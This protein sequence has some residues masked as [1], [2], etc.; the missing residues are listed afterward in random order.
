MSEL[1]DVIIPVYNGEEFIKEA[2]D[3]ILEQTYQNFR[4][5]IVD[6]GS[7]DSTVDIIK[8]ISLSTDKIHLIERPHYG[9]P[10]TIKKGLETTVANRIC[11]LDADDVWHKEKLKKQ[12]EFFNSNPEALASFT[13]IKEFESFKDQSNPPKYKARKE[14]MRG[15]SK[16]TIM[17][18]REILKTY[19]Q[20]NHDKLIGG[21][22]PNI[23]ISMVQDNVQYSILNEV[24][25]YRRV[26]DN[27]M[28]RTMDKND[29]LTLI[30]KH[31][32][33]NK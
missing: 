21:V 31:L 32:S 10:L 16:S 33:K 24:L 15:V 14:A 18:K 13:M 3:S 23:F 1:V 30:K 4:I 26:H 12:I 2:V 7:E 5:I 8:K 17:F 11:F 25:V 22:F 28:T 20:I 9:P 29:Y 19:M 27:N 6:D